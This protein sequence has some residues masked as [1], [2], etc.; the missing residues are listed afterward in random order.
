MPELNQEDKLARVCRLYRA[1]MLALA[2]RVLGEAHDAEDAVQDAFESIARNLDRLSEPEDART[3][4]YIM[5]IT[6]RKAIDL[7]RSRQRGEAAEL[8]E[9]TVGIEFPDSGEHGLAWCMSRLPP[10]YREILL[11]RFVYGYSMR[12]TAEL[13]DIPFTTVG[14]LSQR[15]K[16]RLYE[17][18]KKE[19]VL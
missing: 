5:V 3:R 10:R 17:I 2:R 1:P 6:E 19:G 13:M 9:E 12:E 16:E 4:G 14:K 11:L 15:A 8:D 7:L 18:C